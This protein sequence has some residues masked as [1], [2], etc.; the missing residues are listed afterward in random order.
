MVKEKEDQVL[1]LYTDQK[2]SADKIANLISID[3]KTVF[4]I[5]KR[6]NHHIRT[7]SEA[8]LKFTC[9]DNYFE[10]INTERKAYWLGFL[11]ADGNIGKNNNNV[12]LTSKDKIVIESFL[13]DLQYTGFIT[14]EIHNKYK[15]VIWKAR[16]C[17]SKMKQDLINLGCTSAKSLTIRL[18]KLNDALYSHFVRGY[19][20]GDGC[21]RVS[22]NIKSQD[23]IRLQT[24]ICSG[25]ELFLKDLI[26]ILPT[27]KKTLSFTGVY[28]LSFSIQ[29]SLI[30]YN[31]MYSNHTI[32]LERKY[33]I[34]KNYF[35]TYKPR[36][37]FRDYNKPSQ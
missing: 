18:P 16:L 24:E 32:C 19:F 28:L 27:H 26:T 30:L 1:N 3:R 5:L 33:N 31:Y 4:R 37:R 11:F 13:K 22:R 6:N 10:N 17:S 36:R 12:F 35:D 34:Y 23:W 8:A 21:V 25:S 14:K 7:S 29:D 15:S 2:L 20:D 9:D